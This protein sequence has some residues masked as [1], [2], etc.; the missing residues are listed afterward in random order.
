MSAGGRLDERR[1]VERKLR[2]GAQQ[3]LL[4]LS[5]TIAVIGDQVAGC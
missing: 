5:L 4:A 3:R 1:K 2:D